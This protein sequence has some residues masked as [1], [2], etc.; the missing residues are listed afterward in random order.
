MTAKVNQVAWCGELEDG[1]LG[2]PFDQA[3]QRHRRTRSLTL[4]GCDQ[5]GTRNL[6][7]GIDRQC[8]EITPNPGYPNRLNEL[9]ER[10]SQHSIEGELTDLFQFAVSFERRHDQGSNPR[11]VSFKHNHTGIGHDGGRPQLTFDRAQGYPFFLDFY[12]PIDASGDQ[13]TMVCDESRSV[14]RGKPIFRRQMRRADLQY[15]FL[16]ID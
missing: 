16:R 6:A 9:T 1:A 4:E 8:I 5:I 15:T 11:P 14:R 2:V 7:L 12:D 13:E 10:I 3:L